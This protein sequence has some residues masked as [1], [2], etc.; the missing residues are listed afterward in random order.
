LLSP[1]PHSG[2]IP[3]EYCGEQ[4]AISAVGITRP[5][6]GIFLEA[7]RQIVVL[8]TTSEVRVKGGEEFGVCLR[9]IK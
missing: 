6:P 1:L 3:V 2:D 7:I 5:A 9:S 8:C 4:Q